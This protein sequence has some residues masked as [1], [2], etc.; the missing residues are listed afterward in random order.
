LDEKAIELL[1][2]LRERKYIPLN[3]Y[4]IELGVQQLNNSFLRPEE[5]VR[6]A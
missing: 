1:I 3:P 4:V 2:H 6:R 5:L